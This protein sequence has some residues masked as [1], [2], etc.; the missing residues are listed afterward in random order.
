MLGR[1]RVLGHIRGGSQ[2]HQNQ[3]KMRDPLFIGVRATVLDESQAA[4][5]KHSYKQG[6]RRPKATPLVIQ[7]KTISGTLYQSY[8]KVKRVII[9]HWL[10]VTTI[11]AD[12]TVFCSIPPISDRA[13]VG[14]CW[15]VV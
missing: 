10:G 9:L 4:I 6:Q 3:L 11:F 8:V 7:M 5:N 13:G 14:I 2:G 15:V 1:E 12:L